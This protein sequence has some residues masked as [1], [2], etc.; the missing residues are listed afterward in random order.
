MEVFPGFSVF[1]VFGFAA[2]FL[3]AGSTGACG[4]KS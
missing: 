3:A 1:L 2:A 4:N